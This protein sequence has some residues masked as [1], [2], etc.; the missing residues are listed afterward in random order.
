MGRRAERFKTWLDDFVTRDGTLPPEMWLWD[1]L[2]AVTS[3]V[4]TPWRNPL[5]SNY[6]IMG[7]MRH[8]EYVAKL[9]ITPEPT[10]AAQ[11][12]TRDLDALANPEAVRDSS[13]RISASTISR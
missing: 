3:L 2:F 11:V 12:R 7:P 10:A 6:W 5:L 4:R 8:G 13:W 1:E 9:R